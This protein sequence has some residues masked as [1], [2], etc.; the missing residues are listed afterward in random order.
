MNSEYKFEYRINSQNEKKANNEKKAKKQ[1]KCEICQV[2]FQCCS[3]SSHKRSKRHQMK[4]ELQQIHS[5]LQKKLQ[6]LTIIRPV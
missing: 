3:E 6:N 2:V 4:M 1:V 5:E